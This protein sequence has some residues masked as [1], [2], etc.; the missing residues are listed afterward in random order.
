MSIGLFLQ[1]IIKKNDRIM[2]RYPSIDFLRGFAIFLMVFLHTFMRFLDIDGF[3][4]TIVEG[5]APLSLVLLMVILLFLG[6]WA[7]FFLMVSALGNMISMFKG[8]QKGRNVKD[9]VIKQVIG[10]ILLLIFA[11]LSEGLIGYHGA[12]G[13]LVLGEENW[14]NTMWY[15]GFHQETIHAVAWCVIINGIVQGIL[16]MG[17]GW[18]KIN[19]NIKIYAILAIIVVALSQFVWWGFDALVSDGDFSHGTDPNTGRSW[20]YGHWLELNFFVNVLRIFWQPWAGQVEPLFPFLAV[21][22]IGS[23]MG[24]YLMKRQD[25]PQ[26]HETKPLKVGML[27]GFLLMLGGLIFVA[28]GLISAPGD[29]FDNLL[30]LLRSAFDVTALE[31]DFGLLWLPYFIMV[32]GSQIGAILLVFRVVE[33][34]GKAESFANKTTF[35]RRFGFVAFSIYNFQFIDVIIIF[36]LSFIPGFPA[37]GS[38]QLD[39]IQIWVAIVLIFLL[40][41]VVLITWEKAN[42]AF[43]LEWC[44]A[45]ISEVAIPVKKREGAQKLLWW[46]TPRL[47]PQA[48]L[49]D[50]EWIEII[51][52][53]DIDH[54]NLKESKL[55]F[56][57]GLCGFIFFPCFAL[58][59]LI[60]KESQAT[61]GENKYNKRAKIIGIVFFTISIA[62]LG[63]LSILNTSILF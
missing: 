31:R 63:V 58:A 23:I 53:E 25:E 5:G 51:S 57:L 11:H 4:S 60:G 62:I 59:A 47:D 7:G 46:K 12:I 20:Q 52:A 30:T 15:R 17:N 56:K 33:F 44:I 35:F 61:E 9:L 42:Y 40:W 28:I 2:K 49:Y 45:K 43:G 21:S 14:L 29:P 19:R 50:A 38:N 1:V 34:R 41:H 8:L 32:T 6:S 10:G 48:S 54:K 55:A 39:V 3:V 37:F 27:I 26:N 16:S 36:L 24:L 13:D 22:F 18:K